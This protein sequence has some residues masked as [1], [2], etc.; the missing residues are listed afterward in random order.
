MIQGDSI[1]DSTDQAGA[2]DVTLTAG[3]VKALV[4]VEPP[5]GT[6][7]QPSS[8]LF[9][10]DLSTTQGANVFESTQGVGGLFRSEPVQI[11]TAGSYEFT[12][13]DLQFPAALGSSALAITRGND[14]V[15]QIFGGSKVSRQLTAG[16]YILN[17]I[18]QPAA[19]Q[20]H[21]TYGLRLADAPA[22]PTVTLTANPG[23][24]TSGERTTLQW[25]TA[26]ATSCTAANGW[27]GSKNTSG[28]EQSAALNANATFELSCS[29]PGG[30]SN[31]SAS[32]VV[33]ARSSGGGGGGGS[34][35]VLLL[36]YMSSL[37]L[38]R[39]RARAH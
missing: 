31:A 19:S 17:F 37:A 35:G 33:N 34:T 32:V 25:S 8:G 11:A 14:L 24:V 15:A 23:T 10:I 9:G 1:V 36:I 5:P 12:V 2:L 29:G 16:T 38:V 39:R 30:T 21:G 20:V 26:N 3:K 7:S 27:S 22:A 28:S 13:A 18:G 4:A 6:P